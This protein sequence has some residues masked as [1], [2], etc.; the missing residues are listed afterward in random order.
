MV[1]V[2]PLSFFCLCPLSETLFV[3]RVEAGLSPEATTR[4][5]KHINRVELPAATDA[6]SK[7]RKTITSPPTTQR[8]KP[9][10]IRN[11]GGTAA[12][13]GTSVQCQLYGDELITVIIVVGEMKWNP[14]TLRWEGN[15]QVLRNFDAVVGTSTRPALIT[16][17]TGSSAGS[18][19]SSFAS[20][21]QRVGNMI[22]D[23]TRMCWIS[24]L[25]P[26]EDE[27]DVFADLADD[28]KDGDGWE[29]RGGTIRANL[30]QVDSTVTPSD[31]RRTVTSS[32]MESPSPSLR[33]RNS[34]RRSPSESGSDRGSRASM[35]YDVDDTFMEQT[36]L[37]EERHQKEMKGWRMTL[38]DDRSHLYD[39]RALA[40]RKY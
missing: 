37:A 15:D 10:L 14:Q 31:V 13:K 30:Q 18:P 1:Q 28:E 12:P 11:L 33:S 32:R 24:A 36:R 25:S 22:F 23:P 34:R 27:P 9:T 19:G 2:S 20:G 38:V 8:R 21:A 3:S 39:I 16:Q 4:P 40:T 6:L 26:E 17:L 7:R 35:V 29:E 5:L